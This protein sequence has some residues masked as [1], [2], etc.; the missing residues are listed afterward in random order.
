MQNKLLNRLTN[1]GE[2]TEGERIIKE[3]QIN[4]DALEET[5]QK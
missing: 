2:Q 5:I 1:G 3:H 4:K